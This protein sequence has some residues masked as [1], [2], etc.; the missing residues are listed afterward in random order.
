M[1][2]WAKYL[3]LLAATALILFGAFSLGSSSGS[4]KVQLAWDTEN[5]QRDKATSDL[6]EKNARLETE[7]QLLTQSI[8]T[9]ALKNEEQFQAAIAAVHAQYAD[10]L[11]LATTRAG[12]YRQQAEGNSIERERLASHAAELDRSLEEGRYLVREL[13]ETVKQRDRTIELLSRQIQADRKLLE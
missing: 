3:V 9:E 11:R 13:G 10:R 4:N 5:Q 1:K 6:K 2:T 8:A 12:I 7:N